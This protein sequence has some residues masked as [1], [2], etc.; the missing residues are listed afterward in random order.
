[1][2]ATHHTG[3]ALV[4]LVATLCFGVLACPPDKTPPRE[5][6]DAGP[7]AVP[8]AGPHKVITPQKGRWVSVNDSSVAA[9]EHAFKPCVQCH[10][11]D[12]RG[13]IATGAAI[14]SD[15]FMAAATDDFLVDT[16]THGRPS[17]P[18]VE[19]GS[20]LRRSDIESIVAFLRSKNGTP[21]AE[22][23]QRTPKGDATRGETLYATVCGQCH[24]QKGTGFI[25]GGAGTAIGL[26]GYLNV[27]T[28]G[29]IRY[30][31][32]Q[33]KSGTGMWPV[34]GHSSNAIVD[35][36]DEEIEDVLAFLRTR[37]FKGPVAQ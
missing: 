27:A 31:A 36:S 8:D 3:A 21:A 26:R 7:V 28:N 25:E 18:M 12:A 1:M 2:S 6:A 20:S 32:H 37:P 33:G 34:S 35:L 14:N 17:T 13:K 29:D 16:I 15:T 30:L 11:P 24:G 4:A 10:G 23:D 19:W 5:V 22:L 9:G